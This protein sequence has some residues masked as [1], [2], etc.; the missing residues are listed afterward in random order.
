MSTH[1]RV[2]VSYSDYNETKKVTVKNHFDDQMVKKSFEIY[3]KFLFKRKKN[4][5]VL[6]EYTICWIKIKAIS[7]QAL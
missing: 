7:G 6:H 3:G 4:A 1:G 5:G 2:V